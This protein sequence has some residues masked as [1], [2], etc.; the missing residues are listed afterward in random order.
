[1][2]ENSGEL[3]IKVRSDTP[4]NRL[5][6]SIYSAFVEGKNIVLTAIGPVPISQ[7]IKAVYLANR[8]LAPHGVLLA[9]V[10]SMSSRNIVDKATHEEMPWVVTF[11][12]LEN[13]RE[14]K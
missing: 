4:P 5:A 6:G 8:F 9:I 7:A 2:K 10:P 12:R 11:L 13:I 14:R 1:V 3:E